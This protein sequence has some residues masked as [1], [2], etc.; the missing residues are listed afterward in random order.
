ML[1]IVN[2]MTFNGYN[3][4]SLELLYLIAI[5]LGIFVIISKNPIVSVLFLIGL[6]LC[7]SV[8]IILTKCSSIILSYLLVYIEAVS[9]LFIVRRIVLGLKE[10]ISDPMILTGFSCNLR[11]S[12]FYTGKGKG[13]AIASSSPS[14]SPSKSESFESDM[15][16]EK[17]E[18]MR[19]ALLLSLQ[20][21]N[22]SKAGPSNRVRDDT[23]SPTDMDIFTKLSNYTSN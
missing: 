7:I 8:R 22:P 2:E 6:F 13:K 15:D 4:Y 16:P 21:D 20:T 19:K 1:Y 14:P 12:G 3:V 11:I 10:Y 9:L 5:L 18:N 23:D 17:D